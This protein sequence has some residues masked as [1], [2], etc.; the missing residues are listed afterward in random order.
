MPTHRHGRLDFFFFVFPSNLTKGL[1]SFILLSAD[2]ALHPGSPTLVSLNFQLN[3][4][5]HHL[6]MSLF[7]VELSREASPEMEDDVLPAEEATE[8]TEANAGDGEDGEEQQGA[9]ENQPGIYTE[10]VFTDPLG[11][12]PTDSSPAETQG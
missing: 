12:E 8:A 7:P 6:F 9:D 3:T 4:P 5:S 2:A 10:H 1:I 11:M